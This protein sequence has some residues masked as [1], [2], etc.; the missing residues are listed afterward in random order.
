MKRMMIVVVVLCATLSIGWTLLADDS[1][2]LAV[3]IAISPST[4]VMGS[5]GVWVT[6]HCDIPYSTVAGM[7][8]E[9]NGIDVDFTKAD[10]RGDL[11]AKF[12]IDAVKGIVS[13]PSAELTLS[14]LTTGGVPF[15]GT[16][17]I[18]VVG[19]TGR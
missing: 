10:N 12:Q 4:L 16:D 3:S 7:T 18:R 14:G 15:S 11:V 9:L 19:T 5:Q 17:N 8:V 2:D 6:V 13:P 1:G